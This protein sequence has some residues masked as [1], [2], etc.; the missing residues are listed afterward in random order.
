MN[1]LAS[2][3]AAVAFAASA[4]DAASPQPPERFDHPYDGPTVIQK[5]PTSNVRR[6]CLERFGTDW[7]LRTIKGCGGVVDGVCYVIVGRYAKISS[8]SM[9]IRHEVAHCNGWTA[10]HEK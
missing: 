4:A 3:I 5:L 7:G 8:L 6:Q 1:R 2:L 10:E 9:L